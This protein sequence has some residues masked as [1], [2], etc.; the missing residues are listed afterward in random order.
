MKLRNIISMLA[1]GVLAVAG[2]S[3]S[4]DDYS[5]GSAKYS[6]S[7]LTEGKAYTV[8][9]DAN[10]PN[11]IHLHSLIKGATP[12][13]DTPMGFS[14]NPDYTIQLPFAGE[15][16]I[17]FGVETHAGTVWG[18]P[19]MLT[20]NANNFGM[21]SDEI[22]TNLAGGVDENGNGNPKRWVP[23]NAN[24][25]V[26]RCSGPVMYMSPDDVMN[27]GS[28]STDPMFGSANWTPNWDPG[29][30][31]WLIPA[32]DPYMNSVMEFSLDAAKG[33][34]LKEVRGTAEGDET[35]EGKFTLVNSDPKHPTLSFT[36]GTFAMH[37]KGFDGTCANYT[38][39]I[40]I[41]EC[42]PYLLQLGTMR[43]NSEGPWWLVWNFIA[44]D[45]KNGTV[46]IPTD[47]PELAQTY[48]VKEPEYSNLAETLFTILGQDATYLASQTTLL[49][50]EEKPYD[51]MWWNSATGGWEWINGYGST[52]APAIDE[53]AREAF[54]L[55]LENSKGT[56]KY[57]C[58]GSGSGT[59]EIKGNKLVFDK[60]VTL[61]NAENHKIAGTEF[62]VM[63]C[64]PENDIVALGIPD[65]TDS[66][67]A[68]NRYACAVLR[69]KPIGSAQ[70]G[71]TYLEY[72][73]SKL[74]V[75]LSNESGRDGKL[76]IA[77]YHPW[78][79]T[80]D[81]FADNSKL[82]IKK[83]QS[84]CVTFRIDGI[85]WSAGANPRAH[86]DA[87]DFAPSYCN[88][89]NAGFDLGHNVYLNKGGETTVK[90]TNE[91]GAT[92][93]FEGVDCI[94]VGIETLGMVDGPLNEEGKLDTSAITF[95]VTSV[96]IE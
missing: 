13:W 73:N 9:P 40:K 7:D 94:S 26:G 84:I 16:E 71:P 82:K 56:Y 47:G 60:A 21:L 59:F 10:D 80:A 57:A 51:F 70:T 43:T 18:E 15:Y 44:E 31:G 69:I 29:F 68:V 20:L 53:D 86:I 66:T 4:P 32:D 95:T 75:Y 46:T 85:N 91:T 37:N 49:Y 88:W 93:K 64:D 63:A 81:F 28:G 23:C 38:N 6:P 12:L 2:T 27:D 45:V 55:T 48:P 3:C 30:Q 14:Q 42:T 35:Y 8:T 52:W 58:E 76:E 24:Y 77:L 25:G 61:V 74:K 39:E 19:Y 41:L 17:K 36:G 11:T 5:L 1:T 96:Y 79:G 90:L 22:W 54:A 65:G 50:N 72:D 92:F 78:G 34:V 87:N 33:C 83:D 62:T 67:G 89:S